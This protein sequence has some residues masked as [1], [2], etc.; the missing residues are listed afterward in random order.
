MGPI[1]LLAPKFYSEVFKSAFDMTSNYIT[2]MQCSK[3]IHHSLRLV[4]P[5]GIYAVYLY[6][7]CLLMTATSAKRYTCERDEPV[8]FT[9]I[10]VFAWP[11]PLPTAMI[12]ELLIIYFILK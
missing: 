1:L 2:I 3:G 8:S 10:C 12:S 5:L 11:N 7:A 9:G 6:N 4:E